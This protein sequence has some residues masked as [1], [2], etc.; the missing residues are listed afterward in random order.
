MQNEKENIILTK[1]FQFALGIV[2]L[3]D[4]L[5]VKHHYELA[6]QVMRSGTSIGANTREAQ[7]AVS[8]PD[9]IN[10]LGIALKEADETKYWFEIIDAKVHP[11]D[12]KLKQE[13]EEIIRLLVAII[14]KAKAN[15]S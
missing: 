2:D 7:R 4:A 14:K 5:K 10:K 11:V 6:R 15:N 9:F 8:K 3:Y 1:T 12:E 13:I